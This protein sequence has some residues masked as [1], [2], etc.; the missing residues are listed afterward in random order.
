MYNQWPLFFEDSTAYLAR[1]GFVFQQLGI[2][3]EWSVLPDVPPPP[4][5]PASRPA[6][7]DL[8]QGAGAQQTLA[9]R[10]NRPWMAGRSM[11]YGA[12]MALLAAIASTHAIALVQGFCVS[13]AIAIAWF[14]AGGGAPG[15]VALMALL[16]TLTTLAVIA[17]VLI[18]DIF[19]PITIIAAATLL[20]LWNKLLLADRLVLGGLMCFSAL[21]HNSVLAWLL[22][23]SLLGIATVL[24]PRGRG[25]VIRFAPVW[26]ASLTGIAGIFAFE[27]IAL[28]IS[29]RPPVDLPHL[30]A[31]I[32]TSPEGRE[33]LAEHC[34]NLD[35]VICRYEKQVQTAD[36]VEFMFSREPEVGVFARAPFAERYALVDEQL[37]LVLLVARERPAAFATRQ[38]RDVGRQLTHIDLN[39]YKVSLKTLPE[40]LAEPLLG[41]VRST[42]SFRDAG[43]VL[44]QIAQIN[45]AVTLSSL[46]FLLVTLGGRFYARRPSEAETMA[47][48]LLFGTVLNAIVCA[49]LAGV[50]DRFQ[51]RAIWLVPLAA[52]LVVAE[53]QRKYSIARR[54]IEPQGGSYA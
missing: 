20:T 18:P 35:L 51:A 25:L 43:Q 29:G 36:W 40:V 11:Y 27:A 47:L 6:G 23:V 24:V 31:R 21:A 38:L 54:D 39:D 53:S 12:P 32:A 37:A 33:V 15:Y 10:G 42:R 19:L 50:Y 8:G 44:E 4:G 46:V 49:L 5:E 41:K 16:A 30:S 48:L 26:L 1:P 2:G 13:L 28:T 22:I 17:A 34:Q 45:L 9:E 3:N 14:R 7:L 52:A